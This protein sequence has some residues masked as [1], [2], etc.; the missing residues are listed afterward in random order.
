MNLR[1]RTRLALTVGAAIIVTFAVI[2]C[3]ITF[4]RNTRTRSVVKQLA[5]DPRHAR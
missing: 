2:G 1:L 5:Q 3:L 4:E